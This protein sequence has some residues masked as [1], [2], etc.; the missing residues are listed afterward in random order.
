MKEISNHQI[1]LTIKVSQN[2]PSLCV[3]LK[4]FTQTKLTL[5]PKVNKRSSTTKH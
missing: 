2:W 1:M 3:K 4:I 5:L